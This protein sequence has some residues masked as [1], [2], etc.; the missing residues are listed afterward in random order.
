MSSIYKLS[1]SGIR[2]F[3]DESQETIQFSK[4]LTLI[5]GTNGSGKTTIIECLRYAT[6]GELPPNTRNGAS[7]IND[8]SLHSANETKAQIKLAFQNVNQVNMILSKSLMA[9]RNP[10][11]HSISFKT[12]EN[13][14]MAI[15]NGERQTISSKVADIEPM[16]P[17][18][19]GVSK[20]VLTYVIFC[21]QDDNL[22]PISDSATLKKRFDEIFDSVRFIKV[23]EEM[24][25]ATKEL[26]VEIKV[27]NNDVSHLKNDRIRAR[28]KKDSVIE[29]TTQVDK[30]QIQMENL[31][32][33]IED[34]DSK[35]SE[36]YNTKQDYERTL[37]TMD[38]LRQQERSLHQ[39]IE[40][41]KSTTKIMSETK[42]V[43]QARLDDFT[44]FMAIKRGK[45]VELKK[46]IEM[47]NSVIQDTRKA[48]DGNVFEQG[49]LEGLFEKYE[50]NKQSKD[51][52]VKKYSKDVGS[53]S[54]DQGFL[55]TLSERVSKAQSSYQVKKEEMEEKSEDF[56]FE[57]VTIK[58]EIAKEQQHSEYIKKDLTNLKATK[59]L[60]ENKLIGL[61]DS[62][63]L[64][65]GKRRD[66][67]EREEELQEFKKKKGDII[68]LSK[69]IEECNKTV[70]SSEFE[71][72]EIRKKMNIVRK[73]G[74][75]RSRS[76]V[77]IELNKKAE[78]SKELVVAKLGQ[79]FRAKE[80]KPVD[81]YKKEMKELESRLETERI[82]MD[83]LKVKS[84]QLHS[85]LEHSKEQ[86]VSAKEELEQLQ[87]KISH[88]SNVYMNCYD[89]ELQLDE[90]N[91]VIEEAEEDYNNDF[92]TVKNHESYVAFNVRA[93]ELAK[94]KNACL[95]CH[96]EFHGKEKSQFF[97][98]LEKQN[99][100]LA[101]NEEAEKILKEKGLV[102][103]S[104]RESGKDVSRLKLLKGSELARIHEEI[105]VYEAK[106]QD[107]ES[108]IDKM[109]ELMDATVEKQA[110]LKSFEQDIGNISH[111]DEDIDERKVQIR[112]I[113]DEVDQEGLSYVYEDLESD[114]KT[115]D[116][117]IK[118]ARNDLDTYRSE[119]ESTVSKLNHM[120]VAVSDLKLAVK[121]LELKSID[122]ENVQRSIEET[123]Q[124][125]ENLESI[126]SEGETKAVKLQESYEKSK[127][128]IDKRKIEMNEAVT[129]I[130]K[131]LNSLKEIESKISK[132][133]EAIKDYE[134]NYASKLDEC[135]KRTAGYRK[136][137]SLLEPEV[138]LLED[139]RS[140]LEKEIVDASGQERTISYNI[141]LVGL[142]ADLVN[143]EED[144]SKLDVKKAEAEREEYVAQSQQLQAIEIEHR[145][146]YAMKVGEKTQIQK[147]IDAVEQEIN[148]DYKDVERKYGDQFAKLQMK[149]ALVT[150]LGT[151][152]K[153][154]DDGVMKF[155]QRKMTEINRIIDELWKTTYTGNDVE[156]IMIK[157]DPVSSAK[158]R[159]GSLRAHRSYNYRV[160]MMKNGVEL[161]M[162]GRCSAGQR[163][164]ASIII[165]LALAECFG[166][167]FGMIALDEPTT[168]L[169]EENI[170]SLA[171]ALNKI[172]E[173]RS[174]Q[175]NF[176]LI[177]ITHDEKFLRYMNAVDF[178]DHYYKVARD[179]RLHS[180]ISKVRI[181]SLE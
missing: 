123:A 164:L 127:R 160:V 114:Y 101:N 29:L 170:E 8:P 79:F 83:G 112:R 26:N 90:F 31:Q 53:G 180:M 12:R 15:R 158:P 121:S 89:T 85:G 55:K 93:I 165:R 91:R 168:N 6:A 145:R 27:L 149:L 34:D 120:E 179:E 102:L 103:N 37:S 134:V 116:E 96:R 94:A 159:V 163:M 173:M 109:N 169:D 137:I 58:E 69:Q 10:K 73:N 68:G 66:L 86:G 177:V 155:H 4:P 63:I 143:L 24:K 152:Y 33:E 99:A 39:H 14:L 64:L 81:Q 146:Q 20:A 36:L 71:L 23:L 60:L 108:E 32:A 132:M 144:I 122:K 56:D 176:Q 16:I 50:V 105:K 98:I 125:I 70:R 77:L 135:K 161:D 59:K 19:L 1:I 42:E 136:N 166:L 124:Q 92:A 172:I 142:E 57:L 35:M 47:K 7:F 75:I 3:S 18:Q 80:G 76:N 5:V 148:R 74:E 22:W 61:S 46:E 139:E 52:M 88:V 115:T 157:A 133:D 131:E 111:W 178:T 130:E 21:H 82:K 175:R 28:R 181:T 129:K 67:K 141:E 54:S 126:L 107:I 40:R 38:S 95:L 128:T 13:Q 104:L 48:L 41:I 9:T 51:D 110:H 97:E 151:C 84:T 113:S 44:N 87:S 30:L 106:V 117:A 156:S 150:D 118:K 72:E 11:S 153:A 100:K 174:I 167:N 45:S 49:K 147:Q 140:S 119:K 65:E 43:L 62:G 2:S 162:R 78:R 25:N 17:Q 171:K 138:T 154:T